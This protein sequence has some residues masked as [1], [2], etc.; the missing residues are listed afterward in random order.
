MSKSKNMSLSYCRF[1]VPA[2]RPPTASAQRALISSA[3]LPSALYSVTPVPPASR[4]GVAGGDNGIG[5][6]P[7]IDLVAKYYDKLAA[8][9]VTIAIGDRKCP[10]RMQVQRR[11]RSER[12]RNG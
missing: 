8:R 4:P 7:N 5:Q 6:Q 3:A 9:S 12:V 2:G 10:R 1:D 11:R